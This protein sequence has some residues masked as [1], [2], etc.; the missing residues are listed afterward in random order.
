M[1]S[2]GFQNFGHDRESSNDANFVIMTME[3]S[4]GDSIPCEKIQQVDNIQKTVLQ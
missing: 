3:I 4:C 2:S 1:R